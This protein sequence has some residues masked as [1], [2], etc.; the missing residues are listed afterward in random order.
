VKVLFEKLLIDVEKKKT[1]PPAEM[2]G[3]NKYCRLFF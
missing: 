2:I 3:Q 1:I